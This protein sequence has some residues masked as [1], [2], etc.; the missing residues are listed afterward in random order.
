MCPVEQTASPSR[1]HTPCMLWRRACAPQT[2]G[3]AAAAKRRAVSPV[4][5]QEALL[6]DRPD[7]AVADDRP[8]LW[9][10]SALPGGVLC[11]VRLPS[12]SSCT[13]TSGSVGVSPSRRTPTPSP[14]PRSGSV[15]RSASRCARSAAVSQRSV[16]AS[17]VSVT[18]PSHSQ[19]AP[20]NVTFAL[21]LQFYLAQLDLH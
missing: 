21:R 2:H 16:N 10:R 4:P 5:V 15:S 7:Q 17:S 13:T 11:P 12:A 14:S 6:S 3:N 9:C 20:K 1:R 8:R 18:S 19:T